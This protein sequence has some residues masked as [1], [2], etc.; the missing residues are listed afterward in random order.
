[1]MQLENKNS[2][3]TENQDADTTPANEINN[4]YDLMREYA[5]QLNEGIED[6]YDINKF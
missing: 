6:S 4:D 1:M 3:D 5:R 2:M